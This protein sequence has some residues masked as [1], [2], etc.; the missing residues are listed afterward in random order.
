MEDLLTKLVEDSLKL[1]L[2]FIFSTA[3]I[4]GASYLLFDT[5]PETDEINRLIVDLQNQGAEGKTYHDMTNIH[6][7]GFTEYENQRNQINDI[8]SYLMQNKC[9]DKLDTNYITNT[10]GILTSITIRLTGEKGKISGFLV[11]DELIK[12]RQMTLLSW[13]DN[14][15]ATIDELYAM[16]AN[17]GKE[18]VSD[19]DERWIRIAEL[20][21]MSSEMAN[22][23][24]IQ[25]DQ[26]VYYVENVKYS[27]LDRLE[28]ELTGKELRLRLRIILSCIGVVVG[29]YFFIMLISYTRKIYF[30]HNKTKKK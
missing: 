14:E 2:S 17:W 30:G 23:M 24:I 21:R 26:I 12:N 13:Y 9:E 6:V 3:L 11:H 16:I 4:G 1:I 8:L 7:Q 20:L 29:L 10:L 25:S 19:R 15:L 27:E 18:T 22:Q 28:A 5:Q